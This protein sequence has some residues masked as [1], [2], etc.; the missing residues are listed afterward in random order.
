M[1]KYEPIEYRF[2][3]LYVAGFEQ[4][5]M[6]DGP[7]IRFCIFLQGCYRRCKGCHNPETWTTDIDTLNKCKISFDDI[8]KKIKESKMTTGITFSGGEPILQSEG[9][10]EFIKYINQKIDKKFDI[11][12]FTGYTKNELEIL[13]LKN[14]NI[15]NLL[16]LSNRFV[17]GPFIEEQKSQSLKFRGSLNQMYWVKNINNTFVDG[18]I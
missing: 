2:E 11:M 12:F 16:C 6:V 18:D 13:S 10:V 1:L 7:G 9:I 4:E 17:D 14:K 3:S 5:T 15:K 8:I